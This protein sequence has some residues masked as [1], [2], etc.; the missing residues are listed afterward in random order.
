M[1]ESTAS[2]PAALGFYMPAEWHPHDSTWLSGP[3]D[4]E[5]WPDRVTQVEEIYLRMITA[6]TPHETVN[7]LV[8]DIETERMVRSRCGPAIA[9][10]EHTSELQSHS[11][12]SYAVFCLQK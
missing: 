2:T 7:L 3:K 11:F 10:K 4:P 12:I 8:N 9:A 1:A 6:L 5:T